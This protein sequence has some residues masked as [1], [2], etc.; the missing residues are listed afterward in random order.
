MQ[1]LDARRVWIGAGSAAVLAASLAGAGVAGG[2]DRDDRGRG[3]RHAKNVIFMVGDG[4]S[5]AARDATRLATV[6][7]DG[8]LAMDTLRY[9]GWT[10]TDSADPDEAVTDSAAAATALATGVRTY[11]GAVSVDVDANPVTSLL[12]YAKDLRKSTGLVT[13]AQVTDATPA[14]FGSHVPDRADQSEIAR[15][16]IEVTRPDVILGG[17]EDWWYPAGD[18]GAYP[19]DPADPRPEESRSTFGNL[20]ALAEETGYDYVSTPE[21]LE[22][23]DAD[24]ILGLFANEE[25][26]QMRPE[27]EGDEYAPV[28]PL[29]D[30]AATAL[31]VLSQDEDGFFLLIEEEGVD[32]MAHD[33]NGIRMLQALRSL[34]AAVQVARDYVEEHPDTLLVV[35]GDH[36]TGGLTIEDVDPADESGPGGTLLPEE[37]AT[38]SGEDGPFPVAGSDGKDFAL[39][40]TTTAHTGAPTVV[41][42]R[43]PGS[44]DLV[45]YYPN[46]HLHEVLREVLL[47]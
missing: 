45:G 23:T 20:V 18:E 37:G 4:L 27:G 21:E 33:D 7:K 24:R 9:A 34:E 10:Y 1:K 36:E 31:D 22:A 28:V 2:D 5:I 13:T 32:E 14:A 3:D 39:D 35:T 25:M 19:D 46:T 26:F 8:Q 29:A 6:G 40:W 43:G 38:I 16:F 44:E 42:A 41:T 11:N 15:Q 17:G 30:M 47:G 12:E